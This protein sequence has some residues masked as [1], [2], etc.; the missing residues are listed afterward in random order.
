VNGLPLEASVRRVDVVDEL[1]NLGGEFGRV[2]GRRRGDLHEDDLVSPFG[3]VVEEAFE[4]AELY[5]GF[6]NDQLLSSEGRCRGEQGA[7][8][9]T[10]GRTPLVGSSLSLP[11]MIFFPAY[12][13][14]N[15]SIFGPTP[16][17]CLSCSTLSTSMPIGQCA[18]WVR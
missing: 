5:G 8:R 7:N 3:V 10:L 6:A 15:A 14:L 11:T 18:R 9:R 16:L 17:D 1:G 2:A 4:G 12:I 13:F